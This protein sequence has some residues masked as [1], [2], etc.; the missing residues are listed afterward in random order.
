MTTQ[1]TPTSSA[2]FQED[3]AGST[4]T[5]DTK[6]N[7]SWEKKTYDRLGRQT[8]FENNKGYWSRHEYEDG[9][10]GTLVSYYNSKNAWYKH[11]HDYKGNVVWMEREDG[12]WKTV[13]DTSH[14][15]YYNSEYD[16]FMINKVVGSADRVLRIMKQRG[17]KLCPTVT[18]AVRFKQF[19]VAVRN[20]IF[21]LCDVTYKEKR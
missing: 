17:V 1:V 2:F 21:D 16:L 20:F 8:R 9:P 6:P 5:V 12:R 10:D 4:T 14:R 3:S 18:I 19:K 11:F 7:G 15:V 13:I